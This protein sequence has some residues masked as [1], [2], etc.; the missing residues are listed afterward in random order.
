MYVVAIQDQESKRMKASFYVTETSKIGAEFHH[1]ETTVV[2]TRYST[3]GYSNLSDTE[4]PKIPTFQGYKN[5]D[6]V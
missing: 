6:T 2:P 4:A 1:S 3:V 5:S